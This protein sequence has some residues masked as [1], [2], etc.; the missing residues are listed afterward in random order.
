MACQRIF[1]KAIRVQIPPAVIHFWT[2][3]NLEK[4]FRFDLLSNKRKQTS[5]TRPG[6]NKTSLISLMVYPIQFPEQ[7]EAFQSSGEEEKKTR[8]IVYFG[9][10]ALLTWVSGVLRRRPEIDGWTKKLFSGG[11]Y[12]SFSKKW[13]D[14]FSSQGHLALVNPTKKRGPIH[15]KNE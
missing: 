3:W 11:F 15:H 12:I 7:L 8:K 1:T 5:E 9:L 4:F 6:R 2:I 10:S 13:G 14:F